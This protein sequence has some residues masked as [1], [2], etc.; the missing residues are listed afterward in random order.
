MTAN[1]LTLSPAPTAYAP[2][3]NAPDLPR[4][5]A[6][7]DGDIPLTPLGDYAVVFGGNKLVQDILLLAATPRGALTLDPLYGF[8]TGVGQPMPTLQQARSYAAQLAS[9]VTELQ[10]Q[11]ANSGITIAAGE[12]L[13]DL[14]VDDVRVDRALGRVLLSLTILAGDGNAFPA[15]LPIVAGQQGVTP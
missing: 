9:L 2:P 8:G 6:L 11:R 13:A 3:L 10:Q 15:D 12:R 14:R 5:L 7:V 4:D 1:V